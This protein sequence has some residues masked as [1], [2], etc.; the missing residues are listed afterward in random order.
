MPA[1]GF[2]SCPDNQ[3]TQV[4]EN[5]VTWNGSAFFLAKA[6]ENAT[7]IYRITTTGVVSAGAN[8]AGAT[9]VS[10]ASARGGSLVTFQELFLDGSTDV[11][12][13]R[14]G[15]TGAAAGSTIAIA[16]GPGDH[17]AP[18]VASSGGSYLVGWSTPASDPDL[19]TRARDRRR[20]ARPSP[21]PRGHAG[22][23]G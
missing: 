16:T 2:G 22:T 3:L 19:R 15:V 11:V 10:I 4:A 9:D 13:R 14:L 17:R 12:A 20:H 8:L 23:P 18:V 21:D 1:G 6:C 7:R 5:A